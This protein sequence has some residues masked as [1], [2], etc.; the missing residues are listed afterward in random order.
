MNKIL[1]LFSLSLVLASLNWGCGEASSYQQESLS[2]SNPNVKVIPLD[3]SMKPKDQGGLIAVDVNNNNQKDFII[4]QSRSNL[5]GQQQGLI[6]VYDHSGQKL[7]EKSAKVQLTTQAESEGL[8]GLHAPGVQAADVNGDGK[9]EVLFLTSDKRLHI[10]EGATGQ[11]I[12]EIQ[13]TSPEGTD[14]WEHLVIANF[15]GKGDRDLLLQATENADYRMGRYIAAYSIEDL[16]K[17]DNPQPLWTRNDFVANA[18]N[19]A[20]VGDLDGDG[21]DEVLGGTLI[22]PKGDILFSLPLKGHLDSVLIAD[23]RPDI[24]GLE[25]VGL[26]EGGEKREK[27]LGSNRLKRDRVFL[28]NKK[29]LIWETDYKNWEPQNAAVGD[30]DPS[31]PGLEIWCRSRFNTDQKPFVFDAK[32]QLISNYEF[33][34]T[35]P[36]GWT[37]KG[38]EVIFPIDWTGEAKQLAVAKERH[39][40]GDVAIFDPL[41]GEYQIQFPEQTYRLYVADVSKDWREELIVLST[42]ELRIYHNPEPNPNPKRASLWEQNRYRRSKMTWNYYSP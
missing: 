12:R 22:S 31:R 2:N 23:V 18:H 37:Q 28:Y 35:A 17:Q 15:R 40:Q 30:F 36:E 29:G 42:K 1:S 26:E 19:G 32:G 24:P 27:A 5:L 39:E 21:L 9:I 41:N 33:S 38:V 34:K 8:P 16:L 13:L 6:R 20:R 3:F 25:V 7:W 11:T 10:V 4:T 14:R